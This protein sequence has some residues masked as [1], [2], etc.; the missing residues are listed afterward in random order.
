VYLCVQCGRQPIKRCL[1]L[2]HLLPSLRIKFVPWYWYSR[3]PR[4]VKIARNRS[5]TFPSKTCCVVFRELVTPHGLAYS[6]LRLLTTPGHTPCLPE[7]P[8]QKV[9]SPN[10]LTGRSPCAVSGRVAWQLTGANRRSST[11]SR[12]PCSGAQGTT[13]CAVRGM[14]V[15]RQK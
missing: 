11:R 2:F 4:Y 7:L 14:V 10:V 13:A 1:K 5:L 3:A 8:I 9:P 6:F 12:N 15:R